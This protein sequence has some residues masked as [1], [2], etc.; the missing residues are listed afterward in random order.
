MHTQKLFELVKNEKC[1][2]ILINGEM[3]DFL[4]SFND[5]SLVYNLSEFD[6]IKK[7]FRLDVVEAVK[8]KLIGMEIK[9]G[10]QYDSEWISSI[11]T[12][13]DMDILVISTSGVS[14]NAEKVKV[15]NTEHTT[16]PMLNFAASLVID[17]DD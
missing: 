12:D 6:K 5:N 8:S 16:M 17:P 15:Y 11:V 13:K 3:K 7:L 10:C 9:R 2:Q 1:S 14:Y 4:F